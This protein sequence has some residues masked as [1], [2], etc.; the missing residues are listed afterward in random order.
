MCFRN[1]ENIRLKGLL[2]KVCYWTDTCLMFSIL[3]F[4]KNKMFWKLA[5]Y[6]FL[7]SYIGN[8]SVLTLYLYGH[9]RIL[10][11]CMTDTRSLLFTFSSINS[12]QALRNH[13]LHL[14]AISV[15]AILILPSSLLSKIFLAIFVLCILITCPRHSVSF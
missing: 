4:V 15:W 12:L 13:S 6:S 2:W 8:P 11:S 9:L 3:F 5:V 14:Q 1:A 7:M 10:A